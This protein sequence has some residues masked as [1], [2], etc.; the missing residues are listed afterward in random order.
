MLSK[1]L[2]VIPLLVGAFFLG[3]WT[4]NNSLDLERLRILSQEKIREWMKSET[5]QPLL[6]QPWLKQAGLSAYI[7]SIV[8]PAPT[9]AKET[10]EKPKIKKVTEAPKVAKPLPSKPIITPFA[11]SLISP[12]PQKLSLKK[13]L[14]TKEDEEGLSHIDREALIDLLE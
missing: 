11:S 4:M 12:P 13:D 8:P 9:K 6:N 5:I 14:Q 3:Q 10:S 1:T 2:I 7:P